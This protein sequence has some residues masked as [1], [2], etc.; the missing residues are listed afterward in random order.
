MRYE[1]RLLKYE[2]EKSKL[3]A[4]PLT[5]KEYEQKIKELADKLR[6]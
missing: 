3:R 5:D 6:I 4:M 2:Q 1:E